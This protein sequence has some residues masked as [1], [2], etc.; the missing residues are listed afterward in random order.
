[1]QGLP[2]LDAMSLRRSSRSQKRTKIVQ[3][4]ERQQKGKEELTADR[5]RKPKKKRKFKGLFTIMSLCTAA[6]LLDSASATI[7]T[8]SRSVAQKVALYREN[9]I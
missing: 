6:T 2:Y 3:E 8:I 5:K 7:P 9:Q 1:M 4:N